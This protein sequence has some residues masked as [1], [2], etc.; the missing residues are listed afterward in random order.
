MRREVRKR[1]SCLVIALLFLAAPALAQAVKTNPRTTGVTDTSK[2][3]LEARLDRAVSN[4]NLETAL[5]VYR[6]LYHVTGE[7]DPARLG[8]IAELVIEKEM[9]GNGWLRI[10]AAEI[11]ARRG[12]ES[13]LHLQGYRHILGH[14]SIAA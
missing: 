2:E 12:D 6:S 11:L 9:A 13:G 7:E 4:R 14:R 5:Y 3:G 10:T 1:F 8:A